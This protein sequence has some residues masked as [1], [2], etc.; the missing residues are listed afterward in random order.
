MDWN[1]S[2]RER[3]WSPVGVGM[4]EGPG[5]RETRLLR[6]RASANVSMEPR[7]RAWRRGPRAPRSPR[8]GECLGRW[9]GKQEQRKGGGREKQSVKQS[10]EGSF[11][12]SGACGKRE[13]RRL[14]KGAD[15]RATGNCQALRPPGLQW[16]LLHTL[17]P[18][19]AELW[20]ETEGFRDLSLTVGKWGGDRGAGMLSAHG[21]FSGSP[22]P[23]QSRAGKV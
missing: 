3:F 23:G 21:L 13:G 10:K 8:A 2:L 11:L 22:A 12:C 16:G 4:R 19:P 14:C 9:K 7:G 17:L 20:G 15:D 1:S 6:F 18:A 5:R